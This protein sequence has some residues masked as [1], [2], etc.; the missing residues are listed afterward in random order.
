MELINKKTQYIKR[1]R[2]IE[3]VYTFRCRVSIY[4]KYTSRITWKNC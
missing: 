4:S 1:I 2:I 3:N